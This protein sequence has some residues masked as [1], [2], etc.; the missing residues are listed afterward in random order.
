[1]TITI[2]KK[3][4]Y[5]IGNIIVE[6]NLTVLM[7]GAEAQ[8]SI[9]GDLYSAGDVYI[10]LDSKFSEVDGTL[11]YYEGARYDELPAGSQ[12]HFPTAVVCDECDWPEPES[13]CLEFPEGGGQILS[14]EVY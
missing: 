6:G 5:I 9:T 13:D 11:Y 4:T 10:R 8:G 14:W 7:Q 3:N 12:A 1:M 2:K